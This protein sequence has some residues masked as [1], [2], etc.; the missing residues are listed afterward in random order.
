[1][2]TVQTLFKHRSNVIQTL[3]KRYSNAVQTN[4]RMS[5]VR[6]PVVRYCYLPVELSPVICRTSLRC[7]YTMSPSPPYIYINRCISY[8]P[9]VASDFPC[10]SHR[11]SF[12]AL[13]LFLCFV[14][15]VDVYQEKVEKYAFFIKSYC[16]YLAVSWKSG[17]FASAFENIRF[18]FRSDSIQIRDL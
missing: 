12:H 4:D 14:L 13:F 18:T 15:S 3:F 17:T 7:L 1:M 8:T 6:F 11:P 16:K 10:N 9:V 2:N 5:D